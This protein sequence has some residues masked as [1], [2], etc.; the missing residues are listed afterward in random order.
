M[1]SAS[2]RP[3]LSKRPS[4]T[5]PDLQDST[6]SPVYLSYPSSRHASRTASPLPA[7][8]Q[9]PINPRVGASPNRTSSARQQTARIASPDSDH[10]AWGDEQEWGG[11]GKDQ[12]LYNG[13]SAAMSSD[14]HAS[15]HTPVGGM[16]RT[17]LL[18]STKENYG[19]SPS[20][21]V[22]A[23]RK[24]RFHERDP[25]LAAKD[26]T[27]KKYTYAGFFLI[28][29]LISFVV[30]TETAVYIQTELGW[31]KAYCML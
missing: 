7:K 15:L 20:P 30:Q 6:S 27:R 18:S 8:A 28:L 4:T 11:V 3:H 23:S 10:D 13:S 21:P 1:P 31:N 14:L 25:D 29:S 22:V 9:A 19:H 16:S 2:P 17:P 24:T 5:S 12:E 26:A